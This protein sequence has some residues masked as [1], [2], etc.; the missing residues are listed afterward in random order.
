MICVPGAHDR[1]L[2]GRLQHR[3]A[4]TSHGVCLSVCLFVC[5]FICGCVG[6]MGVQRTRQEDR[7][8]LPWW[9]AKKWAS[10]GLARLFERYASRTARGPA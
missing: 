2:G 9:Q 4:P 1:P 10:L 7:P 8:Q 6:H 3:S 5:V